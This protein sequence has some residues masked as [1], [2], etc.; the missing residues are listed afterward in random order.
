MSANMIRMGG[1]AAI[2]AI[3]LIVISGLLGQ[4]LADNR[5]LSIIL[6]L[7]QTAL[8]VFVFWSTK[9]L[10]NSRN[11]HRADTTI[12]IIIGLWVLIWLFSLFGGAGLAGMT[13]MGGMGDT[14]GVIG[15][16]SLLVTLAAFVIWFMFAFQ[17]M[18]FA[19]AGGGALWK[20][21][22]VLYVIGIVLMIIMVLLMII[23]AIAGSLGLMTGAGILGL[24][25][26]LVVLAAWICHA[27]GLIG[28]A[29]AAPRTA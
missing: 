10:F 26:G 28:G 15:I 22:G 24:I 25:G 9:G 21:I 19:N 2:V 12:M 5:A 14:L 1:I 17:A 4:T 27:I 20:A 7:I 29:S 16:I 6:G 11:Y 23:G 8:I 3:L 18:G 13:S